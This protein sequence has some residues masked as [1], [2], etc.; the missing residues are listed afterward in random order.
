[1]TNSSENHENSWIC[2]DLL[3]NIAVSLRQSE[4][5]QPMPNAF[6]LYAELFDTLNI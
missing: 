6:I 1:M 2:L 5:S 3:Q 4:Y